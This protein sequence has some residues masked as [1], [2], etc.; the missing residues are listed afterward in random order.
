MKKSI[1]FFALISL[2]FFS[3]DYPSE[4]QNISAQRG[5]KKKVQPRTLSPNPL[6]GYY[7]GT[8]IH[9]SWDFDNIPEGNIVKHSMLTRR[10][11][12]PDGIVYTWLE[13]E[14]II[15]NTVWQESY[16]K[17]G[18]PY[19]VAYSETSTA[20]FSASLL[21][22]KYEYYL[23]GSYGEPNNNM[24]SVPFATSIITINVP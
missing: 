3:C 24:S 2:L 6:N 8:A 18:Q 21:P 19:I 12:D 14:W 1:L 10:Y 9:L 13:G 15:V 17:N 4:Q 5:G 16:V 20:P 22:G 11:T 7:D 23:G